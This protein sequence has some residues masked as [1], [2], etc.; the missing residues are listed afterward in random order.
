MS[1]FW[2]FI[3]LATHK[4]ANSLL[5]WFADLNDLFIRTRPISLPEHISSIFLLFLIFAHQLFLLFPKYLHFIID[6]LNHLWIHHKLFRTVLHFEIL[7]QTRYWF[8]LTMFRT[9]S[10]IFMQIPI[11]PNFL[12]FFYHF[13]CFGQFIFLTLY[14]IAFLLFDSFDRCRQLLNE[15]VLRP[16]LLQNIYTFGPKSLRNSWTIYRTS[17]T[18]YTMMFFSF[19]SSRPSQY[20]F[21]YPTL[22]FS[23]PTNQSDS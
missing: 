21:Y 17:N 3:F 19:T 13:Q 12:V 4:P 14:S 6:H 8:T 7:F 15:M 2:I 9:L 16:N 22:W 1:I 18:K 20:P 23:S 11:L 5:L 10:F